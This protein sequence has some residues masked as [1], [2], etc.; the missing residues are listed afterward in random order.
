MRNFR[1]MNPG[2]LM[3]NPFTR[4]GEDW[5]LLTAG[6]EKK[7]NTMTASWGGMG[8][9]W[10]K[11][12][13][14]SFVRPQRYTFGFFEKHDRF[15]ASF[16]LP[17]HR[18]ALNFCGSHSGRDTDKMKETGLTPVFTDGTV[19]FEQSAL[20]FFCRK[21]SGQFLTPDSFIDPA[22]AANYPTKDYHK[23]F[24]GEIEKILVQ[25]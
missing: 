24:I 12:V 10:H 19:T 25:E 16:L 4:I 21:L 2:E 23:M 13:I 17:G 6:D 7:F 1:E 5:M 18:E 20:V 3:L 14:F 22:L 15:T 8:V 11:N 9:L